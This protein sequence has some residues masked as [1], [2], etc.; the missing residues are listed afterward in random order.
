MKWHE[1]Y[2]ETHENYTGHKIHKSDTY[3]R[4]VDRVHSAEEVHR[5]NTSD[6]SV[7]LHSSS[8]W[9][10]NTHWWRTGGNK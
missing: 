3:A 4:V 7:T 8:Q 6:D 1:N 9:T 10:I 5:E 2:T